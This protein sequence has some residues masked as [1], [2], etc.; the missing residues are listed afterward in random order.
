MAKERVEIELNLRG[1]DGVYADLQRLDSMLQGFSGAKGKRA[2]ELDLGQSQQKL[3][4][5]RGEINQTVRDID[6]LNKKKKELYSQRQGLDKESDEYKELTNDI[7]RVSD[8]LDEAEDHLKE[9]KTEF[10]D[11]TQRVNE[12]RYALKN[13]SQMSFGKMF[14]EISTGL[15]HAGQNLQT[16]GNTLTRIGTP[17]HRFTS[18]LL[19]GAGYK[20]LNL[21]TEGL[22]NAFSRYDTMRKY[23]LMM[24]QLGLIDDVSEAENSITR[25]TDAVDGLPT[26]LDEIVSMSQRFSLALG[27]MRRGEDLAVAANNAFLASM[28]TE[29]EQ[30]QGMNQLSDLAAGK[31][32]RTQEWNSLITSM[33]VGIHAV[34]E[35]FG[36]NN[37]NMDEF[38]QKLRSGDI[39]VKEFL[40]KLIEVGATSDSILGQAAGISKQSFESLARN[41]RT[42][43]SRLGADALKA[44]DE[45][46]KNYNGKDIIGNLFEAKGVIDKWSKSLQSWIKAH[47]DEI[48]NFF[49]RLKEIDFAGFARGMLAGYKTI[50]KA[51]EWFTGIAGGKGLEKIGWFMTIAAPLG[52]AVTTF[53]GA[54]KGLSHPLALI[55]AAIAK[56]T[57]MGAGE[58]KKRGLIG[59]LGNVLGGAG[60]ASEAAS[61]AA[62]AGKAAEAAGE[63]LPKMSKFSLGLSRFFKGWAEVATMIGGSAF[64]AWGSMKLIKGAVKSFKETVD[65]LNTVDWDMGANALGGMATFYVAMLG[66]SAVAGDNVGASVELLIGE[67]I[68]GLFT[69]LATGFAA[70]DMKLVKSTVKD[71]SKT[72]DYLNQAIGGLN[73]LGEVTD[74]KGSLDKAAKAVEIFNDIRD[75]FKGKYDHFSGEM[76]SGLKGFGKG[77]TKSVENIA[78]TIGNL[79]N[80]ISTLNEFAKM[81]IDEAG[82]EDIA[83]KMSAALSALRTAILAI[84][85]E[86]KDSGVVEATNNLNS[87]LGNLKS[88]FK[89]LVGKNGILGM[90]P[91]LV[92]QVEGADQSGDLLQ[93]PG[94]MKKLGGTLKASY[95]ALNSGIG[96]GNYMKTNLDNFRQA[97]K[98]AKFAVKH[99]QELGGM[100]V[101]DGVVTN[102]KGIFSKIKE[103]FNIGAVNEI[104][105]PIDD[106][107]TAIKNA[108]QTIKDLNQEI[109]VDVTFKLSDGFYSSKKKV[110]SEIKKGKKQIQ[111]QKGN[112]SVTIPV[113]VW[114]NVIT[115]A[116][117]AVA[118]ITKDRWRV[119]RQ[120]TG[121]R[122]PITVGPGQ[123]MGGLRTRNGVLYRSGGGYTPRGTDT[124]PAM[125]TPG[126][127]V[128]KKQAVDFFGVDFMRKVN[129]MDIRGAME[130]LLNR[131]GTSIGV[132]RQS[133][134]NNTVNNNQRI[135]QHINTNNPNFAKARMGRFVGAL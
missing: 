86:W 43:F 74:V 100:T 63:A 1:A 5:L 66:L 104:K 65:I 125:L 60:G 114:F 22:E 126:E 111:N 44:L 85:S 119:Q 97:L 72:V 23:P 46:F 56:G 39:P 122:G 133:I 78:K 99:L 42:A 21:A 101:G 32:L 29:T 41:T 34:G 10:K 80:A 52:R 35:A 128:H 20:A 134:V 95:D 15:K 55:F 124:V 112:I 91:K 108:L 94:K 62:K 113:R 64:V 68:V 38:I 3:M 130:S 120:A 132:G 87:S 18:G 28:A 109:E 13:F 69:T 102:I 59:T 107:V 127:Y 48:I 4:A 129:N 82:V 49:E 84:P 25:L 73:K 54:L 98:S 27:N 79:K 110:L 103:A 51:L 90:I 36:Y 116:A 96:N 19:M 89:N 37:D 76:T 123:S 7:N 67:A 88:S 81:E 16:L 131:A 71:L 45:V 17:F 83:P 58:M 118:K 14:K 93:L 53:G 61:E 117:A 70:I 135:T 12:L 2:I 33:E 6:K 40:D 47:P 106:F 115:N 50:A 24:K 11:C 75:V 121:Q 57:I 30:Y 77:T 9:T 26:S 105:Q 92:S 8:A 31:Q